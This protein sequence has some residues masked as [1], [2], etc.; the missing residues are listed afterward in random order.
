MA[1]R[2]GGRGM[3]FILARVQQTCFACPSQWDAWTINDMYLYFRYRWGVG[4]VDD[5]DGNEL[6]RFNTGDP[7]GGVI[8][9]EEFMD[10]ATLALS[11][12]AEVS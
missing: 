4:T 7:M 8:T 11:A 12:I 10:R 5:E 1:D 9:L 6:I 2:Y 3:R